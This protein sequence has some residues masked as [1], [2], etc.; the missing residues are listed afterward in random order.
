MRLLWHARAALSRPCLPSAG[1]QLGVTG[2]DHL[3]DQSEPLVKGDERALH[4]VHGEPLQIGP[5][6]TERLSQQSE[7]TTHAGIANQPVVGVDRN[8]EVQPSKQTDRM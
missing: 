2:L 4:R 6:V 1:H 5:A 7:L 8:T 3:V